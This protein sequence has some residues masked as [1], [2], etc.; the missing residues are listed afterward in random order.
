MIPP[1]LRA[2][3]GGSSSPSTG[4]SAR[5]P[6]LGVHHDTVERAIEEDRFSRPARAACARC[7]STRTNL[8]RA[9]TLEQ[10]PRL[11]ATRL[12]EMSSERGYAGSV[13]Q[14]AAMCAPSGP[15]PRRSFLRLETLPGEQAQV[16]WGHF[17][18][19]RDRAARMRPAVVLRDGALVVAGD[20]RALRPRPDAGEFSARPRPRLRGTG[21]RAAGDP[22]RQPQ[23]RRPGA[24]RRSRSASIRTL[25]DLAGHYHFAPRPCAPYRGNEKGRSSEDSVPAS[26]LLRGASLLLGRRSERAA[27]D[28]IDTRRA[29]PA[30]S[31][32]IPSA[33]P[34]ADALARSARACLPLARAPLRAATS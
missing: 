1:E 12:I 31:P 20:V 14:S 33:R 28:W 9:T 11:R 4:R 5:S 32:A 25:L 30:T 10:H 7:C 17:G 21:R 26:L 16:D 22:L 6:R 29:R 18:K 8:H 13:V 23:E 3:S 34:C 27:A 15:S 19:I 24:R 2:R